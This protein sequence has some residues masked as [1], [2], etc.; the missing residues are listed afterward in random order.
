MGG[1]EADCPKLLAFSKT[2]DFC[3]QS[4]RT[5]PVSFSD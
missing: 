1:C 5:N 4:N 2:S 3:S